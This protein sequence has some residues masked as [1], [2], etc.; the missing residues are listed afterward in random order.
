MPS[1]FVKI[2]HYGLMASSNA[3]TKLAIARRLI[4]GEAAPSIPEAPAN[5]AALGWRELL[6][7]LTG[8]DVTLCPACGQGPLVR[9]PLSS[10]AAAPAPDT[11]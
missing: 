10:L 6:K 2:R 8:V 4:E 9:L 3:K 5:E 1:G 7:Q 11:S